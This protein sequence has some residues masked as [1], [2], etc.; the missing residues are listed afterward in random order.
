V[1]EAAYK[2]SSGRR[3]SPIRRGAGGELLGFN[4]V[5]PFRR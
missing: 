4:D 5:L 1:S 3:L 2:S